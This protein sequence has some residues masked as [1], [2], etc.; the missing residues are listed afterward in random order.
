MRCHCEPPVSGPLPHTDHEQTSRNTLAVSTD[1]LFFLAV[2]VLNSPAYWLDN[3]GGLR[4]DWPRVPLP[5]SSEALLTSAVLD[6]GLTMAEIMEVTSMARRLAALVLLQ[7]QLDDNYQTAMSAT[8]A[9]GEKNCQMTSEAF[10]P[11]FAGSVG[12]DGQIA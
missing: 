9:F 7:P 5:A 10:I 12:G 3:A 4:R 11:R 6:R 1:S 8:W 2:A